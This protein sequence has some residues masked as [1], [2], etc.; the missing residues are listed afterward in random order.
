[1]ALYVS[2][3][4]IRDKGI[5]EFVNACKPEGLRNGLTEYRMRW[6]VSHIAE[7]ENCELCPFREIKR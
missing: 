4:I 5:E 1:M 6:C 7:L 3:G 2:W